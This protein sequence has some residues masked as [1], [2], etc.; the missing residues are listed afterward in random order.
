MVS[1]FLAQ[2]KKMSAKILL[3]DFSAA[4]TEL[5]A[6]TARA[7]C[8]SDYLTE[9]MLKLSSKLIDIGKKTTLFGKYE[10]D[11]YIPTL[12][13]LYDRLQDKKLA[14]SLVPS[15]FINAKRVNARSGLRVTGEAADRPL[16]EYEDLYYALNGRMQ[17]MHQ[18]LNIRLLSGFNTITDEVYKD[19]PNIA[20]FHEELSDAWDILN[21]TSCGKALDIAVR[22]AKLLAVRQELEWQI[23][24][25]SISHANA[26]SM[27]A[28]LYGSNPLSKV[29]GLTFLV[30]WTPVMVAAHLE[31]KY[32]RMLDHEEQDAANKARTERRMARIAHMRR[33][34]N[35][36]TAP[37]PLCSRKRNQKARR[38]AYELL[39]N[40]GETCYPGQVLTD[41]GVA[42]R[43]MPSPTTFNMKYVQ[44]QATMNALYAV[45]MAQ[46][47]PVDGFMA[48]EYSSGIFYE[49]G[50]DFEEYGGEF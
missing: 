26:V 47:K 46:N 2:I 1:H 12:Q 31:T 35:V 15:G 39:K 20:L 45:Q 40:F 34:L 43:P 14:P 25:N 33:S 41:M 5:D 44:D 17:E 21:K 10:T 24:E 30:D 37:K 7:A 4:V 3:P 36:A 27:Q 48:S 42:G 38:A 28:E 8:P 32:R 19:G 29:N 11:A 22:E 9:H 16:F 13:T 6:Q 50:M 49:Q 23:E 18:L